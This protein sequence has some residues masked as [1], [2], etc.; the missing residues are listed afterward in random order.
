MTPI[1][2]KDTYRHNVIDSLEGNKNYGIELG[3]AK[4]VFAERM[5]RSGKFKKFF[6][7]DSYSGKMEH[8]TGEYKTALKA[9]GLFENYTLLRMRF[10]QALDLFNNRFFD[11]IYVDGF[12]YNGEDEG[13]TLIDWYK[14]VKIGGIM[15]GDD[16][17]DDWP[18]VM[19]VV[20]KFCELTESQLYL[21]E[22]T[23]KIPYCKSPSWLIKKEKEI[24]FQVETLI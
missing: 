14:K 18:K 24:N 19:Q 13:K 10:D 6:G 7:V 1:V 21:T 17:C 9:V 2:L 16:Y 15:A 20:N 3:V 5:V 12:A 23:E 8:N 4:G 11:F 22:H